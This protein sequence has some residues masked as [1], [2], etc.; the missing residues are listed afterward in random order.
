VD[1]ETGGAVGSAADPREPDPAPEPGRPLDEAPEGGESGI[2]ESG[3]QESGIAGPTI[4]GAEIGE[5][6]AAEPGTGRPEAG[7]EG[8]IVVR[9]APSGPHG[10]LREDFGAHLG[11]HYPRLVGQLFAITLDPA[12]A[13]DLVQ[14]AYSRAWRSWSEVRRGDATGW[15]RRVAVRSSMSAWRR[16]ALKLRGGGSAPR[17]D[18]LDPRTEAVLRTLAEVPADERR[19]AVL[20]HMAG[21]PAGEVAALERVSVGTVQARLNRVGTRIDNA[22]A[23]LP[24][25]L[26]ESR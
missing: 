5:P 26:E 25:L 18:N 12:A 13:H 7:D 8:T 16:F 23:G 14:D 2:G 11:A 21:M 6:E 3:I 22:V 1:E 24:D 4:A 17:Q 9:E 10:T 19:T 20:V 15:I